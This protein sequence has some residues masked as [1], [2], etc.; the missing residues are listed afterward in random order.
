MLERLRGDYPRMA[1]IIVA[2]SLYSK[3]PFVER[4]RAG[5]FSFLLVAQEGDHKSLYQDVEGLRN[6]N[7]L[8]RLD[9]VHRGRRY[10][11]EWVT[12]VPLNG[13]PDAPLINFIQVRISKAGEKPYRNAWVTDL[14]PTADNIVQLVR[15]ARARWKIENEGF[16]TLKNQGYHLEHNFGHGD[17]HLSEAFFTLNLLAFFM[18]QIFEL[19]DG[20]YQRVR[21][22]FSSR[23]AFWD[24]VR[25][26][27]RLFLFTSWDQVLVRM[28]SPPVP[29]PPYQER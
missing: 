19:V 12:G 5:R 20:L 13:Q 1:A 10:E 16:N 22:F 18:H 6:G 26:A 21:T 17:Q 2:D 24:E 27:F 25:S 23:R 3:Q 4:L 11:Y 29:L 9:T 8:D 7:L 15:A 28:N 14:V